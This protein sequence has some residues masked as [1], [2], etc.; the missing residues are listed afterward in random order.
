MGYLDT[1][2]KNGEISGCY[3]TGLIKAQASSDQAGGIVGRAQAGGYGVWIAHS[4][5][6]RESM[7]A[8]AMDD[9]YHNGTVVD[10]AQIGSAFAVEYLDD[11]NYVLAT[12][13][14]TRIPASRCSRPRALANPSR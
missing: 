4:L 3:N 9:S 8:G 1:A 2:Y 7:P 13:V 12:R 5:T 11:H 10:E 6:S 14:P